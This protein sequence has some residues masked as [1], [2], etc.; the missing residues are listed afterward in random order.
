ML[1]L[2]PATTEELAGQLAERAAA[3]DRIEVAGA[4]SKKTMGGRRTD[5]DSLI[6]VAAMDRL[7]GY[8]PAD[9]TI[10]VQAGMRLADL[11]RTLAE[12]GQFLPLDPPFADRATIGGSL[13]CD[14]SG[15][16]RRR[17]GTGR[18]MVIGM[19]FVTVDGKS[20]SSGGMVVKNV[21]GLDMAK[22]MIGSMGTLAVIATV[23]LKVT[24]KPP[25]ERTFAFL[26]KDLARAESVRRKV[27]RGVAQ[28]VALDLLNGAAA[29]ALGADADAE[30]VLLAEAH[31]SAAVVERYGS[32]F[33]MTAHECGADLLLLDDE[34]AGRVWDGVRDFTPRMLAA[35]PGGAILRI[36]S[37]PARLQDALA[38]LDLPFVARAAAGTAYL[39]CPDADQT[40]Q[41][42]AALRGRGVRVTVEH[43]APEGVEPWD[44]L[45]APAV[46]IMRRLKRELDPS[47]QLNPGRLYGVI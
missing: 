12:R 13:A 17:Y 31:G 10:S 14:C 16:R 43:G 39:A 2:R 9:L 42:V 28:P 44:G 20:V 47:G 45:P 36:S 21:T 41:Q 19:T 38:A 22:L 33:A 26:A 8:E 15:P 32:D 3:G 40:V 29:R 27:L 7:L 30:F 37:A 6:S 35:H 4:L 18:D 1:E 24:P 5:V 11:N 46:D 23:N 34:V 25:A